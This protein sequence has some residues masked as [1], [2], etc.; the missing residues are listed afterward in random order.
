MYKHKRHIPVL[1]ALAAI[2]FTT[3]HL[4][5]QS[6]P[7]MSVEFIISHYPGG[8][9]VSCNNA[10]DG[11]IETRVSGG[12]PPYTYTWSNGAHTPSLQNLGEGNY[13]LNVEDAQGEILVE[14]IRILAPEALQV[15][16]LSSNY[17]GFEVSQNT[18][19]D[20]YIEV[21]TMGGA[22]PYQYQW[23]NGSVSSKIFDLPAGSYSVVVSDVNAC[24][25]QLHSTLSEPPPLNGSISIL[26][27]VS[28]YGASDGSAIANISGGVPPYTYHWEKGGFA[29][30][31]NNLHAGQHALQVSD[32]NHAK[33]LLSIG[34]AEPAEINISAQVSAYPNGYEI[35]CYDCYNGSIQVNVSGGSSPY[36]YTWSGA[37]GTQ[38]SFL[39]NLGEGSYVLKINDAAGCVKEKVFELR[40]PDREDWTLSGNS[41][42]SSQNNFIGTTDS[43]SLVFRTY[44]SERITLKGSGGIEI[45]DTLIFKNFTD[46]GNVVRVLGIDRKGKVFPTEP[47]ILGNLLPNSIDNCAPVLGWGKHVTNTQQG[48]VMSVTDD[49]FKCPLYGNVGIGTSQPQSKV[50]IDGDIAISGSRLHVGH[51]NKIG[52]HTDSPTEA[53]D[54]A[55]TTKLRYDLHT[56]G[57]TSHH[58]QNGAAQINISSD[59]SNGYLDFQGDPVNPGK[60][61]LN[62]QSTC[63]I[64]LDGK[65]TVAGQLDACRVVVEHNGWC[66]YVFAEG[67]TLP[68]LSDVEQF[69]KENKHLPGIPSEQTLIQDNLDIGK[70]QKMQMEK[71]EQLMLYVIQLN[72][73]LIAINEEHEKLKTALIK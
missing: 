17:N 54:V 5:A 55:G 25:A 53:L 21:Q 36:Q 41:G 22:P 34:I 73:R 50:D 16:A 38:G 49:I 18:G 4:Y 14:N 47:F 37:S 13:Q 42:L 58:S 67:Y 3:N 70:M 26:H 46:S 66:D 61:I 52:I 45:S 30:Q 8:Y 71:I 12:T 60:L 10:H 51:D 28:C 31:N 20:G 35:S 19:S 9:H 29:A 63:E 6:I 44:N 39:Q 48:Q 59:G 69:I 27:A 1:A 33:I 64:W 65:T 32:A 68:S 43:S 62:G 11:F 23:S 56:Y 24:S 57:I 72:H 15:F 2:Y 40:R 7:S